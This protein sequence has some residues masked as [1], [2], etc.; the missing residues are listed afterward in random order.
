MQTITQPILFVGGGNM[1]HA[2]ISGA[3]TAK[4]VDRTR[5]GV[6]EPSADR[7]VL[8]ANAFEN[9]SDGLGWLRSIDA[10]NATNATIVLA[11]KPQMLDAVSAPLRE[12]LAQLA[13][14]PSIVSILAGTPIEKLQAAFGS[15]ARVIRVMPNTP[16]QIGLGMSAISPSDLSTQ[17]DIELVERLFS[18]IGK[19]I[20]ISEDLMDAF[21]GIAGSGPAYVFYLAQG[22]IQAA[23]EL[24]FDRQQAQTIVRQTIFG[25]ATLMSRSPESPKELRAKVTSKNGTTHAATSSLDES[26]VMDAIVRAIHAA[27]HR[28]AQLARG[29]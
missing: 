3:Q 4:A 17:E 24:G 23:I 20:T 25:S 18:S 8:F 28:G 21:T 9:A 27:R 29:E 12:G 14:E 1:A 11:I 16:T 22:M 5:V 7:R 2:I 10:T 6:I 15:S 13:F 26:G 19:S